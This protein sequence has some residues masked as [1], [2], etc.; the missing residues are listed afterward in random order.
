MA[1][2]LWLTTP[3]WAQEDDFRLE[4]G[5]FLARYTSRYG[6]WFGGH[7]RLW[8]LDSTGTRGTSGYIDV[9]DL[10]WRADLGPDPTRDETIHSTFVVGRLLRSLGPHCYGFATFGASTGDPVFPSVQAEVEINLILP[11]VPSLVFAVGGGDR[12]YPSVNRPY[13]VGGVSYAFPRS[14]FI[15]RFWLG[16]GV[17]REHSSTH[18]FTWAYGSRLDLWVR[19]DL[20]W[21]DE[22]HPNGLAP[23]LSDVDV[24]SRGL[25]ATA[26]K[27][28][29]PHFGLL[30]RTEVTEGAV[31]RDH[32]LSFHRWQL[33]LRP[34]WTF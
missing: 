10:H 25:A 1:A 22:G 20:L 6:V 21:G 18:L 28:L 29:S 11:Q 17:A 5:G 16:R 24:D 19:L 34:F 3:A 9:V 27:W 15:Y 7:G 26:E 12:L 14:A 2:V 13:M 4:V 23:L 31:V 30:V 8:L 33:E 32:D